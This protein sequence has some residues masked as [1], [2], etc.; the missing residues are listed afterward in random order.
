MVLDDDH[1][2]VQEAIRHFARER[3]VPYAAEWDRN[4]TFPR[5]VLRELGGLGALGVTVQI[6]RAHV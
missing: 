1:R 6:G 4:H 3:I 5:D 2:M